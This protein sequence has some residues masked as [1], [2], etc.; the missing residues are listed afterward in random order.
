MSSGMRQRRPPRGGDAAPAGAPAHGGLPRSSSAPLQGAQDGSTGKADADA[1]LRE[2]FLEHLG[3]QVLLGSVVRR[4][5]RRCC[6]TQ[7]CPG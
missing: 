4:T 7:L 6:A 1:M 5:P 2:R 3:T